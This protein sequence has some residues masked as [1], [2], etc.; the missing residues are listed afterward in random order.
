MHACRPI[1]SNSYLLILGGNSNKTFTSVSG[2]SPNTPT[3]VNNLHVLSQ[4]CTAFFPPS[5]HLC[6]IAQLHFT[7]PSIPRTNLPLL[8][9]PSPC[10]P[11]HPSS[12]TLRESFHCSMQSTLVVPSLNNHGR[13]AW[14][15]VRPNRPHFRLPDVSH[16]SHS[17]SR[18][19]I[20]S[21]GITRTPSPT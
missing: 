9:T 17:T 2:I 10:H 5:I 16:S 3:N 12:S 14:P 4:A 20:S 6:K 18:A 7:D 1:S 19:V 15:V 13:P 21:C 8:I 11:I